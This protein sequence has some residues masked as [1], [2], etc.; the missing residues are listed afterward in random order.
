MSPV[1]RLLAGWVALGCSYTLIIVLDLPR[2]RYLPELGRFSLS[3]GPGLVAMGWYG[4]VLVA[5]AAGFLAWWA[6][7]RVS[8]P[9]LARATERR[10]ILGAFFFLVGAVLG[11]AWFELGGR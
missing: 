6:A 9:R 8:M 3:P 11:L 1:G 7:G 10:L 4:A 2:P 5:G